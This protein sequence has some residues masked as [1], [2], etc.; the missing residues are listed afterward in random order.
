MAVVALAQLSEGHNPSHIHALVV[1]ARHA[2]AAPALS[3]HELP[4]ACE[5]PGWGGKVR[6]QASR[7]QP[8]TPLPQ[9]EREPRG[10]GS[11]RDSLHC[12][13]AAASMHTLVPLGH[14][15]FWT[16]SGLQP[17]SPCSTQLRHCS[18]ATPEG[19]GECPRELTRASSQDSHAPAPSETHLSF[20]SSLP[21]PP[22]VLSPCPFA[23]L[24]ACSRC[25]MHS[26]CCTPLH[27]SRA[28]RLTPVSLCLYFPLGWSDFAWKKPKSCPALLEYPSSCKSSHLSRA[29]QVHLP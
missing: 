8:P 28:Q 5:E 14:V 6:T 9:L 15:T 29:R 20:P 26:P 7:L 16:R 22:Q 27:G 11:L 2:C 17:P 24:F 23:F 25:L 4:M 12:T 13:P 21:S 18:A 1:G 19:T 10:P 3:Q